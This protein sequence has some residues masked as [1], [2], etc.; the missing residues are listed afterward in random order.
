MAQ[1]FDIHSIN[2]LPSSSIKY[3]YGTSA[4]YLS[5]DR[6]IDK[7]S[8]YIASDPAGAQIFIDGIEQIGFHTPSMITDIP[9]GHHSIKLISSGYIDIESSIP[10]EPGRTY[11]VFLTMGKSAQ[12]PTNSYGIMIILALGL[13]FLLLRNKRIA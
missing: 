4:D 7:S 10:L 8:I 13:G 2:G 11:N 9:S 1:I 5:D 3:L 6:I 12:V